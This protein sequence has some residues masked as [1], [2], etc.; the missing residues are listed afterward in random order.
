MGGGH[1]IHVN[2]SKKNF[3]FVQGTKRRVFKQKDK[4]ICEEAFFPEMLI[5][6]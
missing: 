1:H 2:A 6:D 3:S 4:L 5:R